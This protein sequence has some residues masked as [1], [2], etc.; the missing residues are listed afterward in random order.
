MRGSF[1]DPRRRALFRTAGLYAGFVWL[2]I[3]AAR[4]LLTAVGAP[5]P[6]L[7]WSIFFV[8]TGFTVS[9]VLVRFFHATDRS[10][11][12]HNLSADQGTR[13]SQERR[14][15]FIA[16]SVLAVALAGSLFPI[17]GRAGSG[18]ILETNGPV[19]ILI[20]DFEN[21]TGDELFTDTLEQAM[22]IGL[23][24]APFISAYSRHS[25]LR[26]ASTLQP[27]GSVLN[28]TTAR[29]VSVHEGIGLVVTG[30]IEEDNGGYSLF[31][32]AIDPRL[33]EVL[34]TAEVVAGD[35]MEVLSAVD[36]LADDIREELGDRS[37][38]TERPQITES[39]FASNLEAAQ[40][41]AQA[42]S[43]QYRGRYEEAME[44][45]RRALEHD[46]D[47]G[48]AHSGL[49]LSAFSLGQTDI[50]DHHW[51]RALATLDTMTERERLRTLGLYY[52]IVTRD[53]ER[54]IMT[55]E[56]LV[57]RYPADDTAHNGLAVQYFFALQ[58]D[59]ALE[60]GGRLL[61]IY[62]NNVMGRSNYAL[63]AMYASDFERAVEQA[64]RVRQMDET[65]F[66]AWLPIAMNA[67]VEGNLD[68][69]AFA[70]E[71]MASANPSGQLTSTLGMADMSIFSGDTATA[72]KHL[73]SGI[74]AA[75][76][77]GSQYFLSTFLIARA[78][79]EFLAGNPTAA[80]E[81]IDEALKTAEGL[82]RQVPA[83]VLLIKSGRLERAREIADALSADVQPQNRAYGNLIA[84][85]IALESGDAS[86]A[87]GA[88][89]AG[90]EVADLWLLRF[91]LGCVYLEA[92][93]P[94]EA[95]DTLIE[96][97]DRIGEATSVFL[98]D[99][100]TWRYTAELPYWLARAQQELGMVAPSQENYAVFIDRRHDDDPLGADARKRLGSKP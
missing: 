83:A 37:G 46:P 85:L 95:L 38:G 23:E 73:E 3:E 45:Y 11:T 8:V 91:Y 1:T 88:I 100:P 36:R 59:N 93:R 54:A 4:V 49:A 19:S 72:H 75:T 80:I 35:R 12:F 89:N 82:P 87:V 29:L 58:F 6:V 27:G 5:D 47:L 65:Y 64:E 60:Q 21:N 68:S 61:E 74:A 17:T 51:E 57:K 69:A 18:E 90:I 96:A 10:G 42:Q 66:K 24:G 94:A 84:G 92:G 77:A 56:M 15:H 97:N 86:S 7:R 55:Y 25:A 40:A 2:V 53:F 71:N 62:P 52:S 32:R 39:F 43:L 78:E 50:S 22:Q 76:D 34:A 79:T 20:A 9:L 41:Y 44:H 99:L 67:L 31:V 28:E 98:D 33:G 70:Y 81:S 13:P 26:V 14:S 63:Y 16:A 30:R 48:R